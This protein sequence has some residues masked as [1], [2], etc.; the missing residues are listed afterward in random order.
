MLVYRPGR[1][2]F[3]L[4]LYLLA[5]CAGPS[6]YQKEKEANAF[7]EIG[8]AYM[9]Q[10]NFT[11]ALAEFLKAEKLAP[12]DPLL[13][14]DL[15]LCYMAKNRLDLSVQHFKKAIQIKP[16]YA[17]ARNNLGTAYLSQ[18]D[19]DAAIA[20]FK[21]ITKDLLYATPHYPLSNLGLAYFNKGDYAMAENYY[22]QALKLEPDFFLAL[23][24]LG[25]TNLSM[26]KAN[27]A[28][29]MLEKAAAVSPTNAA[30]YLDLAQ[31]YEMV[32]DYLSA[33]NAYEKV[34]KIEPQGLQADQ[35]N[36]GLARLRP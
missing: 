1:F 18:K 3:F 12:N 24:G 4:T 36:K 6:Q 11:S 33:I 29:S 19:W 13:H 14:N 16:D 25:R 7:K 34:L 27:E 32:G 31:A 35:A 22:Q 15:G 8:E 21:E 2:I 30:I 23:R 17:A 20:T 26:G 10:R 9:R 28:I 5:A